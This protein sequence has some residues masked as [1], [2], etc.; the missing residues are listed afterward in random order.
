MTVG[1]ET[2]TGGSNLSCPVLTNRTTAWES[3]DRDPGF[4]TVSHQFSSRRR[5]QA[6]QNHREI[7]F[8]FVNI[9][10]FISER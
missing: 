5:K 8:L 3:L 4:Q 7:T 9:Q 10:V 6:D 1:H 2:R